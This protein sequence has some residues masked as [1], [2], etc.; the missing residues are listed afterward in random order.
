MALSGTI[1]QKAICNVISHL[2][3]PAEL[4][5]VLYYPKEMIYHH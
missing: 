4:N 2:V 3:F 5:L 1:A